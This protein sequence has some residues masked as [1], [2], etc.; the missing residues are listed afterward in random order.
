MRV[1]DLDREVECETNPTRALPAPAKAGASLRVLPDDL[2][3]SNQRRL[4]C[5]P[6]DK[7]KTPRSPLA[8]GPNLAAQRQLAAR[9]RS[10]TST[11]I[12]CTS[13]NPNDCAFSANPDESSHVPASAAL[14]VG[15]FA[16]I[17]G[18]GGSVLGVQ[19]ADLCPSPSYRACFPEF[20][21]LRRLSLLHTRS[22]AL[23]NPEQLGLPLAPA[24]ADGGSTGSIG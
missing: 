16:W 12:P 1:I 8:T 5:L 22:Q 17:L 2:I 6:V 9:C 14:W 24:S 13:S 4:S 7:T 20:A 11:P 19:I 21:A 15:D 18:G 3:E 23:S 10:P